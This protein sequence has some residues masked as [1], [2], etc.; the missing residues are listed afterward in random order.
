MVGGGPAGLRAA[1]VA[2]MGG[3]SVTVFDAKPSVGRKF[4]VA[5]RGGMNITHEEPAE[6]FV[7]RYRSTGDSPESPGEETVSRWESLLN[8]F[9]SEALRN[10]C[11]GLGIETFTAS[12]GRVYP[13]EM[14]SAPLLRRWVARLRSLGVVFEMRQNLSAFRV[15]PPIDLE[16]T[17]ETGKIGASFDAVILALGGASWPETGSDGS[18]VRLLEESGV[19]IAALLPANCG[20]NCEWPETVLAACEGKPLKNIAVRVGTVTARGELLVTR[21]GLE[22]GAIYS[23]SPAL[24]NE[25]EA[26]LY[27]DF[28]PDV[29][30]EALIRRLGTARENYLEE[31]SK[32]WRLGGTVSAMLKGMRGAMPLSSA[33]ETV[34]FVKNCPVSIRGARP[35]SEA[36]SSSGG[37]RFS[38]VDESRMLKRLPGMFVAGEMLDWEAPTGGY[39]MQGCFAT[40]SRAGWGALSKKWR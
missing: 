10:W 4:L 20:W 37:V 6:R 12:T 25:R 32:R 38:E 7:A 3:A 28:K 11:L 34:Q 2:A 33:L 26:V 27:I 21:Y 5:G 39:L 35:L 16:F 9:G 40:G 14:K 17:S 24:R 8:G 18:W 30:A 19:R 15:G 22:G 29:S 13:R 23:V 31:A 1:E 36:I